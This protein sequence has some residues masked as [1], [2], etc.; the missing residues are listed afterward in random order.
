MV[1]HVIL[2]KLKAELSAGEK[3]SV[4]QGIKSALEA[5]AGRIPGLVDIKVNIDGLDS[6]TADCMLDSTFT[7]ENALKNYS[8]NPIHQDAANTF[9]RPFVETRLCLDFNI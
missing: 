4:K 6:S 7:D 3:S 1:K 2:W 5:L 8:K 9:V